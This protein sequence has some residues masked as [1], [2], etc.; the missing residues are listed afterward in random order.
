MTRE[1]S[2]VWWA[3]HHHNRNHHICGASELVLWRWF[4]W[5]WC[6]TVGVPGWDLFMMAMMDCSGRHRIYIEPHWL[7]NSS[8]SKDHIYCLCVCCAVFYGRFSLPF[9]W[10]FPRCVSGIHVVY[11]L[12]RLH[13]PLT[14]NI[15]QCMH[16]LNV[17]IIHLR[18]TT[19]RIMRSKCRRIL[20]DETN[21]SSAH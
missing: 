8:P 13:G 6:I 10:G 20:H 14:I 15:T 3:R 7:C 4:G 12:C 21:R 9:P 17:Q 19:H 1:D 16:S 18:R 11:S 2:V 5:K